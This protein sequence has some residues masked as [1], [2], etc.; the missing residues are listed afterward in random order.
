LRA[1]RQKSSRSVRETY[2]AWYRVPPQSL[3][4]RRASDTELT[5]AHNRLPLGT[6][7]RVINLEN[8]KAVT[9]RITDRGIT[10]PRARIDLCR[11]AAR[12]IGMLSE[13][14]IKVRLEILSE[15]EAASIPII[16]GNGP[17]MET[18]LGR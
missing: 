6:L 13:G 3:A 9:V 12:Q 7:V 14:I 4:H 1:P 18:S 16:P 8:N 5:A 10:H 2:A 15:A 17:P 11:E